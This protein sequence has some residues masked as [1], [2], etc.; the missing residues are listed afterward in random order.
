MDRLTW[1]V[2]PKHTNIVSG[3]LGNVECVVATKM[4][5][6]HYNFTVMLPPITDFNCGQELGM[7]RSEILV[8]EWLNNAKLI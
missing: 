8:E 6:I 1:K 2:D 7:R 3:F 5:G 4:R